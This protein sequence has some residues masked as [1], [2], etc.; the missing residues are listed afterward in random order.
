[1]SR[2]KR[3][4]DQPSRE[5]DL[6]SRDGFGQA[7]DVP[8]G[9]T[10]PLAPPGAREST[11]APDGLRLHEP[12]GRGGMGKVYRAEQLELERQVA[13]KRIKRGSSRMQRERFAREARITAQ[14]DHPNIVPV[15]TLEL[16][17]DG[18]ASGYVMKLV[19]GK[20]L[21][22]LLAEAAEAYQRGEPIDEEH[23]LSTRLEH[24][25][26][27]CDAVAFA[28]DRGVIHRDLKPANLMIGRFGEVYV[29][30]WGIA[31]AIGASESRERSDAPGAMEPDL[32]ADGEIVGS[33]SYM[34]PEQV[35]GQNELLDGRSDQYVLGLILFEML[36]LKKAREA[37]STEE[38]YL[39]AS[40]GEI[41]PLEHVSKKERIPR[42]LAAIVAKATTLRPSGRYPSVQALADDVR[43]TMRGEAPTARPDGAL[44]KLARWMSRHRYRT[45]V[46]FAL[47]VAGSAAVVSASL[48]RQATAEL[49]ERQRGER[50][51]ELY[52]DVA[53]R[54]HRIDAQF[55]SMV[56]ALEGLRVAAEWALDGPE[57]E[58]SRAT[59]Y[60]DTDFADP[61]RRPS[62]FGGGTA[63]RWPVSL[64]YPVVGVPRSVD[65]EAL[66]PKL[67]RLAPLRHHIR[68]M[69]A[70]TAIGAEARPSDEELRALLAARKSPID[71]AYVDLAEG[72]HMVYPG[73]DALPPDYDVRTAGFY[74]MSLNQRGSRWGRPYVDS[75]TDPLGDDLVLPCT[76]GLW[77]RAGQFLGVAGV[78]ITVTKL[79]EGAMLLEGR[80]VLR[81]SLLDGDGNKVV[82][83]RDAGRRF[84]PS[85]KDE[86]LEL[87][88][89]DLPEVLSLVREKREGVRATNRDGRAELAAVARLDVLGWYYVVEVDADTLGR[90]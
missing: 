2:T 25:L 18:G 41:A 45:L 39:A 56:Q 40:R 67:A 42:D 59:V 29:M 19:E 63:Y 28:H 37:A 71:Y 47:L 90:R 85:G 73:V 38:L 35:M 34:S 49:V 58:P 80:E 24:F 72:A 76:A 87:E 44:G 81:A 14:L 66:L 88:P 16:D 50:R 5:G 8:G 61:R 27:I 30:D 26:K 43:R 17:R 89:F 23:A 36:T 68:S 31:R 7:G 33:A 3:D 82:D 6:T 12:I 79:V 21:R 62:D 70:A 65:R 9:G 69:L 4:T 84:K 55:Q 22:T 64:E 57:P 60:F 1:L 54:A 11:R 32:T 83:S 15:H 78:E 20:T 75:T 48:Y 10:L 86:Y 52:I 74:A 53:A 77:S 51:T 13:Y 46:A